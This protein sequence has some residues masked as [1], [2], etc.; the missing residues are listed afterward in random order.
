VAHDFNNILTAII[1]Y[2]N[3]VKAKITA[4]DLRAHVDQILQ[5]ADRA[6]RLTHGLLAFSRKQV[7]DPKPV[8]INEIIVN[9]GKL[10]ARLIGE[11]IDLKLVLSSA[12]MSVLA[13]SGQIEQVLMNLATNARDAMPHG[14]S[15][16]IATKRM[17]IDAAFI[18]QHGYG[19]PGEY[20][21]VTVT[22]TG[23]GMERKTLDRIFEPFFTTKELGKGTGLGLS[24][25]YGIIKQHDGFITA[26]SEP[27]MGSSFSVYLRLLNPRAGGDQAQ[28]PEEAARGGS[29]TVLL[30]EDD[31]TVRNL[32]KAVLAEAGYTVITAA[33]GED[34]LAKF[35]GDK[36]RI[37][38]L[39]LDVIMPRKNGR[40][41]H[42]EALRMR[43]DIKTLFMSGYAG[44][45]F[46]EDAN[47]DAGLNFI[48]KPAPPTEL[49]RKIRE[50][51][52]G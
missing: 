43:P 27:G 15:L 6:A 1:G 36:D 10:L 30:A 7:L 33:D 50:T 34:A 42:E 49:L 11:D 8:D 31:E 4:D 38:L 12:R 3:L 17:K 29:E 23:A 35:S 20:A 2:G 41:V 37:N 26:A 47:L 45:V 32:T 48:A 5:A 13:D 28:L 18:K 44:D 25:V 19:S 39:L 52:D 22:D 51:L 46:K 16:T 21:V 40:E 9:V 14:G 24:I